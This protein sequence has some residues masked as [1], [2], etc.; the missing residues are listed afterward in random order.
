MIRLFLLFVS[1]ILLTN[2]K[3]SATRKIESSDHLGIVTDSE[4][5]NNQ[6]HRDNCVFSNPDTSVAGIIIRNVE[7]VLYI[8]GKQILLNSDSIHTI[9]SKD[10]KQILTLMVHPGDASNQI[11]IFKISYSKTPG[12][13]FSQLKNAEF[14]TEKGIKLGISKSEIIGS[15]GSCYSVK[16]STSISMVLEYKL[17]LPNDSK[18]AFLARNQ[19]P[20]YFANYYLINNLLE[21]FE[22]GFENP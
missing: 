3:D 8:L 20:L 2:C 14:I 7:S 6:E 4:V 22:F 10:K 9:Y 17:E 21:S 18:T 12:N 19:M 11:S 13:P 16:D 15:L 5:L 1:V